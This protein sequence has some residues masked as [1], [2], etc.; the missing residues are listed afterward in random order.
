MMKKEIEKYVPVNRLKYYF[1]VDTKYVVSKL[2]LLLFPFTHR[3]C[4]KYFFEG[5]LFLVLLRIGLLNMNKMDQFSP[6][7]K[8]MLQICTY[9]QWHM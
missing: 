9:L 3:V 7:M 8:L 6:D 1:A 5:K 4:W 2:G